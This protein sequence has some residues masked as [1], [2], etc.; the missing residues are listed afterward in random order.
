MTL[1][2]KNVSTWTLFH[3]TLFWLTNHKVSFPITVNRQKITYFRQGVDRRIC[4]RWSFQ[5]IDIW[6]NQRHLKSLLSGVSI[7]KQCFYTPPTFV[8]YIIFRS[9]RPSVTLFHIHFLISRKLQ[10]LHEIL[11]TA[12]LYQGLNI[13]TK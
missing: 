5:I 10:Y 12:S 11:Y 3:R 7:K 1:F 9:V 2:C 4:F 13:A 8:G 6:L